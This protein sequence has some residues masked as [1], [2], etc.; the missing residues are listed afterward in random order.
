[1]DTFDFSTDLDEM[2]EGELRATLR[3]T[4]AKHNEQVSDAEDYE[5]TIEQYEQDL[6]S[7]ETEAE[8]AVSYFAEQV[9]EQKDME[10]DVLSERFSADEL[11]EML[12]EDADPGDFS[13]E[14]GEDGDESKFAD[15]PGKS[16]SHPGEDD[17]LA[18]YRE[19]ARSFI[20][21]SNLVVDHE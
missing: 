17:D 19:K 16:D 7:A 6:E 10:E 1:M 3:D 18:E 11:R 13:E 21:G 5:Q 12:D 15:Q 8:A 2:G 14:D 9:A 20:S 4:V